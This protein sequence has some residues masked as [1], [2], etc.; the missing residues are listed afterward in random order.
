MHKYK[1][2]Q[3]KR[4]LLSYKMNCKLR[5]IID[6]IYYASNKMKGKQD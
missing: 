1:A 2:I 6:K 5:I 3:K 4:R